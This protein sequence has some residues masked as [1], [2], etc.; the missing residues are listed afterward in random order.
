[1]EVN[2]PEPR[3]VQWVQRVLLVLVAC[4]AFGCGND[5]GAADSCFKVAPCGG[6]LLGEWRLEAVCVQ[7]A[8]LEASFA[9]SIAGGFCPTQTL[10]TVTRGVSGNLVMNADLTFSMNG[11]LTGTTDF[12]VPASCLSGTNCAAVNA[13]LQAEIASH[14]E[15]VSGSCSGTAS[16][17]CHQ[18]LSA[19][20][21]GSG[22]YSTAGSALTADTPLND[23]QYCVQGDTVH[24]LAST[25]P[26]LMD[27]DL[28]AVRQ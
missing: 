12:T 7:R 10:G 26:G 21:A 8:T 6:D 11:T 20:F 16:C 23:S 18:V 24:F 22:T 5:D 9:G 3:M 25:M 19:P 27:E 4:G 14:P 17:L 28:V 1:M 13:S 2:K 15:I